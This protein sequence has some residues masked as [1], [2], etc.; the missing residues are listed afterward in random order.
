MSPT[1][2]TAQLTR[3][4]RLRAQTLAEI[5]GHALAQVAEGGPQALSL[6]AVARAM[7]MS[8][9]ALYRYFASR[10]ELL[11]A[12]VAEAYNTLGASLEATEAGSRRRGPASKLRTI[13]EAYREWALAQPHA[14]RLA[15]GTPYNAGRYTSRDTVP[16][17]H[18]SM[19]VFLDAVAALV[20]NAAAAPSR[21]GELDRQLARWA[22][23]R[24]DG[25][26]ERMAPAVLRL[27][28]ACW[29][30]LHGLVSL[31]L[32]GA[33]EAVGINPALLFRAEVDELIERCAEAN[34]GGGVP[35][36][37]ADEAEPAAA[38]PLPA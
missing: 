7:G 4:E 12:L 14:Y 35:A 6:N 10:D 22:Q 32:E 9:P 38:E 20:P 26:D 11:A 25:D 30:R 5:T 13:A 36:E 28:L 8:G 37:E 19:L 29:T 18:R 34:G 31:E 27:G 33:F 2:S 24:P 23:A 15:F 1:E 16:A 3:R 21:Q 17:A